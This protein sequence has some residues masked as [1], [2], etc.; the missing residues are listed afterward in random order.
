MAVLEGLY[1]GSSEKN[2]ECS[3]K[4]AQGREKAGLV[5]LESRFGS[6]GVVFSAWF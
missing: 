1:E 3:L 5:I 4:I 6:P 2:S